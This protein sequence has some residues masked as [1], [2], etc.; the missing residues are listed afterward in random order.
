MKKTLQII[1]VLRVIRFAEHGRER[2]N[3]SPGQL[4]GDQQQG[5]L[6]LSSETE[7]VPTYAGGEK[8]GFGNQ[9][10]KEVRQMGWGYLQGFAL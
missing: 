3:Q 2:N 5:L 8:T 7:T 4:E 1:N 10:G 9:L 6:K